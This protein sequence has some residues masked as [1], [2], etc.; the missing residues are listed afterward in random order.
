[1]SCETES[2]L[3]IQI[4]ATRPPDRRRMTRLDQDMRLVVRPMEN[5]SRLIPARIID[6][7]C[8]GI[9]AV[10]GAELEPGDALQLEFGLRDTTAVVRLVGII[11]WREGCLYGLEFLFATAQDRE[12]MCQAFTALNGS[13]D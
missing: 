1:M 8:C 4:P 5:R 7:S 3:A 9:R 11:R 12:R 6:L 10:I 13:D 2:G